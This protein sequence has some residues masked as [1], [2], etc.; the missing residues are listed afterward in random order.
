MPRTIRVGLDIDGVL[1][2]HVAGIAKWIEKRY[3][4]TLPKR[5]VTS[6]NPRIKNSN[7][8][9]L[10]A[11]AYTEHG[12]VNKLPEVRG[13]RR[14]VRKLRRTYDVIAISTRPQAAHDETVAWLQGHFGDIPTQF[15]EGSKSHVKVDVL[16]DDFPQNIIDFASKDR[17]GLLFAQPW[18]RVPRNELSGVSGTAKRVHGWTEVLRQIAD[19]EGETRKDKAG[20]PPRSR[21]RGARHLP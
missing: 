15:V 17:L 10:L 3:N 21:I 5:E 12:V 20:E 19:W 8:V 7:L 6:W 18:N 16:V 9:R 14:A 1:C 13:A 2:D 11:D 4:V